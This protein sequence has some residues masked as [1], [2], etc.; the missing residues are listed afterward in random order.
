M[1]IKELIK[2]LKK[3]DPNRLVIMSSDSEGNSFS[4][5]SEV[6]TCAYRSDNSWS[7]EVGLE[8]PLS[9][10]LISEGY[11]QEDIMQDGEPALCLHPTN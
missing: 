6:S 5:L 7:G 11:S 4:P 1:T 10:E 9:D 3:E 8:G 2:L